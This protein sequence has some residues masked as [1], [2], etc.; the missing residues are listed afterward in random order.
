[1]KIQITHSPV[2]SALLLGAAALLLNGGGL[3]AQEATSTPMRGG[4]KV[5]TIDEYVLWRSIGD[6]SISPDG[7]WVTYSFN[8]RDIDGR[9][10]M[11]PERPLTIKR[12]D[13]S[14]S[15]QVVRG[16]SP[17]FSKDS[18][19]IAYYIEPERDDEGE[20]PDDE[21]RAVELRNLTSGATRRWESAQS[22]R[23]AEAGGAFIV[24]K[25]QSDEDAEHDGTDLI[26]RYL[27]TGMDDLIAYVDEFDLDEPG[28]RLAYTIDAPEGEANG[29]SLL[30][31]RSRVRTV[32]DAEREASYSRMTWGDDKGEPSLDALA[33]LKG[34]EHDDLVEQENA[35]LMWP[36]LSNSMTPV[37]LD[38]RPEEEDE[39]DEGADDAEGESM[40]DGM[41]RSAS[42]GGFPEDR[43]LSEKGALR[44][45]PDASRLFVATRPQM[46]TPGELCT[47]PEDDDEEEASGPRIMRLALRTDENGRPL[48]PEELV[49][50]TCPEFV[51]D[52][53]IWHV[54]DDRIQSIQESRANA[55]RN[56]THLGV[57]HI[58][59]MTPRYVQLADE[60]MESI[61]ISEDGRIGMGSDDRAYISDWRPSYADYYLVDIDTGERTLVM[62]QQLRTLGFDPA[63]EHFL[64]WKDQNVWAYDIGSGEHRDVT[65]ST[66]VSF[67]DSSFDRFG[68]K[69]PHGV[70]DWTTE[71]EP[72][73][74]SDFDLWLQPLDGG[75]PVNLTQGVGAE[76]QIRFRI[77]DL[78]P[79]TDEVDLDEPIY[80]TA[81]GEYT[82]DAG[83]WRLDGDDMEELVYTGARFGNP[84]KAE[85]ADV[86]M[87]TQQ[88]F[89][90]FP[91]IHLSGLDFANP[92]RLT[93]A[94]P[95]QS[96][97][98]WG[99]RILFDYTNAEGVTKQGTLAIPDDYV[100]GERR[101]M[102][103]NYY[104]QN[105]QN[106]HSYPTPRNAGS[107]NFAGYVSDGYLVMQPDIHFRI[108][109]SHSDMLESIEL[110]LDQVIAMG[111]VDPDAVGIHG[112]SYSGQGNAYISTASD[113]FAAV[114]AGAAATN[115]VSDFNALWGGNNNAH[116]YDIYGQGRLG[117]DPYTDFELYLSQ[118]AVH[119]AETMNTPLL[120]LHGEDDNTVRWMHAVEFYN[121]LR[122]LEKEVILLS[123][124][125][126]G[127]GLRSYD[128]QK[129]FQIRMR[130]FY[131]HHL[132]GAPMPKWMEEGRP[133]LAKDRALEMMEKPGNG[134]R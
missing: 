48:G 84:V 17:E 24:S 9:P 38:P 123:Y 116:N 33:V 77:L 134:N 43:V 13:G 27:D 46:P 62:E 99:R 2:R 133:F 85:D 108:G 109:A 26:I 7:R 72:I 130:Q 120:L 122:W 93:D 111:Y 18:E 32:L 131:E 97:Y 126:E 36:A 8:Y 89:R 90:T 79:E 53:D 64:Y 92:T 11:D 30:D 28:A 37:V 3:V 51:A 54:E 49:G 127:H 71:G 50:E 81:Y 22:F 19:W 15:I 29:I 78:D 66:P 114:V 95:Q 76:R 124:P 67:V 69:P 104:E 5:L 63:A 100:E 106:L 68:E 40:D 115:L 112:H 74:E 61:S 39:G 91:D 86:V 52:V 88:D 117:T 70:A 82:K 14:D 57:V 73:M 101:P 102:L 41:A 20:V 103:I 119:N 12:A 42:G 75:D 60:S 25:R 16:A 87:F 98:N 113:R 55:D 65:G 47:K 6:E 4:K 23:F 45:A 121:G 83:F 129:D 56:R 31:L 21:F 34:N 107:P 132:R 35:V 110:A 105:S 96:E 128:N 80:L 118:S 1:M 94:N 44:W 125:G 10:P 58:D 59:N